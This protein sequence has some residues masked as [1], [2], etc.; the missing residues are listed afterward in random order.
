MHEVM[1][2]ARVNKLFVVEDCAQAWFDLDWR[3]FEQADASLFSFGVIKT[4]TSL[5]GALCRVKDP[6]VLAQLHDIQAQEPVQATRRFLLRLGKYAALKAISSKTVFGWIAMVA[7]LLRKSVDDLLSGLT[8]G[9]SDEDLFPQLRRQPAL[10]LLRM[11]KSRLQTYD[12][13]R[14]SR[15]I[16][17]ARRIITRLGLE[18]SQPELLNAQHSFWLFPWF[19]DRADEHKTNLRLHGFDTTQKGSLRI[20]QPPPGREELDCPVAT[21]LLNRTVFLPCY[22]EMSNEAIDDMCGLITQTLPN[23]SR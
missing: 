21:Y 16:E 1:E 15:R 7:R 20:L 22:C 10:G 11:L 9:F 13:R 18:K 14:V 5:G 23:N 3:G 2:F 6:R 17:N 19:T 12:G 8:R 4:A